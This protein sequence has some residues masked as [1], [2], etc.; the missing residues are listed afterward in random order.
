VPEGHGRFRMTGKLEKAYINCGRTCSSAP[1]LK[2]PSP[3]CRFPYHG[4]PCD[5]QAVLAIAQPMSNEIGL[6]VTA[7]IVF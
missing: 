2:R 7:S 6:L 4:S 1:R 3:G 5:E